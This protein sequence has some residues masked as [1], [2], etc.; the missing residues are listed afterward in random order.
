MKHAI[1]ISHD[2]L[3]RL[4]LAAG[5][6]GTFILSSQIAYAETD[7]MVVTQVQGTGWVTRQDPK[8][9]STLHEGDVIRSG[10]RLHV[11]NGNTVQVAI[12][13]KAEDV[14]EI[15]EAKVKFSMG[16]ETETTHL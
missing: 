2:F 14:L 6:A 12:D 5:L 8:V 11:R 15:N 7:S 10:D 9:H 3:L 1:A 4:L 16:K 13:N